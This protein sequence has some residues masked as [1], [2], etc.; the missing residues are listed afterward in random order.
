MLK[1]GFSHIGRGCAPIFGKPFWL[2]A[3]VFLIVRRR[4]GTSLASLDWPKGIL[5]SIYDCLLTDF[6]LSG[7]F[8]TVQC[9]HAAKYCSL[10]CKR[11]RRLSMWNRGPRCVVYLHLICFK[12]NT[13]FSVVYRHLNTRWADWR[14]GA[15]IL[16]PSRAPLLLVPHRASVFLSPYV[17][18]NSLPMPP[19]RI[20]YKNR[21]RALSSCR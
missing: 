3:V 2:F 18:P 14:L 1:V 11:Q 13:M 4:A 20:P 16:P 9:W 19:S 21:A 15:S 10:G 8:L 6:A 7:F 5:F 17:A 12:S